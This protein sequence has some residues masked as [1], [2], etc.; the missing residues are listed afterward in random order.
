VMA[1]I[2]TALAKSAGQ[3]MRAATLLKIVELATIDEYLE[4]LNLSGGLLREQATGLTQR[5]V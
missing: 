4:F 1:W 3:P 5:M 2:W